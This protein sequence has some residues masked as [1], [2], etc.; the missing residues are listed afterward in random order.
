[1]SLYS[2]GDS[3]ETDD[4]TVTEI[5]ILVH[6]K[7][8]ARPRTLSLTGCATGTDSVGFCVSASTVICEEKIVRTK[9]PGNI[10]MT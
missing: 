4:F 8:V 10:L 3:R 2:P 1:M 9:S 5:L 6:H 7:N